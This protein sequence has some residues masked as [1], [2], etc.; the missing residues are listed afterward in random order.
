MAWSAYGKVCQHINNV[1]YEPYRADRKK[2]RGEEAIFVTRNNIN[3][4][5]SEANIAAQ[6]II[7]TSAFSTPGSRI[8]T[9]RVFAV[10]C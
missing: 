10:R 6:V 5:S 4:K 3:A 1:I 2:A 8:L 9:R 7:T